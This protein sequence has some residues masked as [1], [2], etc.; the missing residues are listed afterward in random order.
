M[1]YFS[2]FGG[3]PLKMTLDVTW[4]LPKHLFTMD[5]VKVSLGSVDQN[6]I[7]I[8]TPTVNQG[9]GNLQHV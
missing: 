4:A 6:S 3:L 5:L 1:H 7:Q 8:W 2:F 9:V